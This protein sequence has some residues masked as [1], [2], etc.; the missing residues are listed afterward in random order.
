M[1][2]L[3]IFPARAFF[4]FRIAQRKARPPPPASCRQVFSSAL[5]SP[6]R[7]PQPEPESEPVRFLL[8]LSD[9][10][11]WESEAPLLTVLWRANS[12]GD[13]LPRPPRDPLAGPPSP[14]QGQGSGRPA[15]S[16]WLSATSARKLIVSRVATI[17]LL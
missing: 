8:L 13:P 6:P 11:E 4:L 17:L 3:T 15:L 5:A 1:L 2:L 9:P 7:L 14:L 16:G 12:A 10:G